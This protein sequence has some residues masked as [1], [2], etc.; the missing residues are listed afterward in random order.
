MST[1]RPFQ[2]RSGSSSISLLRLAPRPAAA[3]T[4]GVRPATGGRLGTFPTTAGR[5]STGGGTACSSANGAATCTLGTA[6]PGIEPAPPAGRASPIAPPDA[7]CCLTVSSSRWIAVSGASARPATGGCGARGTGSAAGRVATGASKTPDLDTP[8]LGPDASRRCC[9]G[10]TVGAIIACKEG[11][12]PPAL[13]TGALLAAAAG[14]GPRAFRS[15]SMGHLPSHLDICLADQIGRSIATLP[16]AAPSP[17]A[18]IE[19]SAWILW[20]WCSAIALRLRRTRWSCAREPSSRG[21]RAPPPTSSRL[22]ASREPSAPSGCSSRCAGSA[23]TIRSRSL[24]YLTFLPLPAAP[25]VPAAG[26]PGNRRSRAGGSTSGGTRSP[27]ATGMHATCS[28]RTDCSSSARD[29]PR[30]CSARPE[31]R[32][33]ESTAT[34]AGSM[35]EGSPGSQLLSW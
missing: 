8:G 23:K 26:S 10:C 15:G 2:S 11:P 4:M 9:G 16:G 29:Q 3:S 5:A 24:E 22:S 32:F 17:A 28:S 33:S 1:V 34:E 35:S 25:G 20:L 31:L 12:H 6:P 27:S 19:L 18:Y 21:L 14:G 30:R 7:P 13:S